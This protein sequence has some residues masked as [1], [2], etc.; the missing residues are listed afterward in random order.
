MNKR[1]YI[2]VLFSCNEWKS[3]ESMRLVGATFSPRRMKSLI[4]A[5]I[6]KSSMYYKK[7]NDEATQKEQLKMFNED[8]ANKGEN[9]V[10]CNLENGYVEIVRDGVAQ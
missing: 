6:E 2:Y 4:K 8:Y 7:G 3:P 1:K 10:F 9:F 5:E